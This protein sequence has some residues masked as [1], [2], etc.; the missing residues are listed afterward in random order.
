MLF[1][2]LF[3]H[4]PTHTYTH[5]YDNKKKVC[6][7]NNEISFFYYY[8]FVF[9]AFHSLVCCALFIVTVS[10]CVILWEAIGFNESNKKRENQMPA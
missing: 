2:T 6:G 4:K 5:K 8:Y 10:N 1:V 7:P 3:E 9:L